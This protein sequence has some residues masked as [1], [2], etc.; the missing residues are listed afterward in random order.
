ML[1]VSSHVHIWCHTGSVYIYMYTISISIG[2]H[3]YVSFSSQAHV[4]ASCEDL[5][6][7]KNLCPAP[8]SFS[9]KPKLG[10]YGIHRDTLSTYFYDSRQHSFLSK[11]RSLKTA[12][13]FM[14]DM[15]QK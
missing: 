3:V 13:Q 7:R 4:F 2:L 14:M 12:F 10:K 5:Y 15:S 1:T 8:P 11:Q 9:G 6:I